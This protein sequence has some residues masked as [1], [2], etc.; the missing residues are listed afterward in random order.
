MSFDLGRLKWLTDAGE[1]RIET[2]NAC[3]FYDTGEKGPLKLSGITFVHG[4][5]RG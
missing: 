3:N 4:I 2:D 1:V 5:T